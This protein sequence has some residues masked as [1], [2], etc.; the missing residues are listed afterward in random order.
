MYAARVHI[1]SNY[2]N[3]F[4]QARQADGRAQTI[5]GGTHTHTNTHGN[6]AHAQANNTNLYGN[7]SASRQHDTQTSDI[8]IAHTVVVF[9]AVSRSMRRRLRAVVVYVSRMF[10]CVYFFGKA[11]AWKIDGIES[12]P[13][14]AWHNTESNIVER[15]RHN[16]R[17]GEHKHVLFRAASCI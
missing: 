6:D 9:V 11:Y 10:I 12:A 13:L 8:I 14:C 2:A 3:R 15:R 4:W 5:A 16:R 17:N 7:V 1:P